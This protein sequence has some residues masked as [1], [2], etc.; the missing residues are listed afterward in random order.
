MM[1]ESLGR[2]LSKE[3]QL[4]PKDVAGWNVRDH[5]THLAVWADGVAALL[6]RREERR[7]TSSTTMRATS[8]SSPAQGPLARRD[9]GHAGGEH[10]QVVGDHAP[11]ASSE[12]A[13]RFSFGWAYLSWP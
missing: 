13:S 1:N 10:P 11:A 8:R 12:S 2:L 5:L 7:A 4:G 9:P 6:L 3:Q